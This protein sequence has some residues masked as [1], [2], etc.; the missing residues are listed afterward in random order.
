MH[1]DE[2]LSAIRKTTD[3]EDPDKI[4]RAAVAT[5]R[6]LSQRLAGGAPWGIAGQLPAAIA[7]KLP[8][9]GGGQDFP[10]QEFYERVAHL[11]GVSPHE[12]RNHARAVMS[13]VISAIGRSEWQNMVAQLPSEYA[14]LAFTGPVH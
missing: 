13:A 4:N 11:E 12:A 1:E 5:L 9:E 2:F 14:D 10:L 3:M 8:D 7:D 6:V